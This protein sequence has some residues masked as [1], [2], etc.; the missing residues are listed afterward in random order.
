[1]APHAA[2][3]G[4]A[5]VR[6]AEL[7]QQSRR[8]CIDWSALGSCHYVKKREHIIRW[9]INAFELVRLRDEWLVSSISL[10]DRIAA[11][12]EVGLKRLEGV[13]SSPCKW[14]DFVEVLAAVLIAL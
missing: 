14:Q 6:I 1:M 2:L 10:L 9:L 5:V 12:R 11:A 4:Q 13:R 3:D 8:V 7:H